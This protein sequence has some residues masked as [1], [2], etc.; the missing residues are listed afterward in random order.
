MAEEPHDPAPETSEDLIR[1]IQER[2]QDERRNQPDRRSSERRR[3]HLWNLFFFFATV[4]A[5]LFTLPRF[6]V[7]RVGEEIDFP[8]DELLG[9]WTTDDS[10]YADRYLTFTRDRLT[11]GLGS[12]GRLSYPIESIRVDVGAVHREYAVTYEGDGDEET[13]EVFV[14][15]DGLLRLKNPSDIQWRRRPQ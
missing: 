3:R 6:L 5:V 8:P 1:Q 12:E 14:Y 9:T 4:F 2:V 15:D 11:L 10:R 7:G 13:M